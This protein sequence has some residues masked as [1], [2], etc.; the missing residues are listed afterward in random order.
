VEV[1]IITSDQKVIGLT[2]PI[3]HKRNTWNFP[4]ALFVPY[5]VIS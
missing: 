5:D 2:S 1:G 3:G 4:F